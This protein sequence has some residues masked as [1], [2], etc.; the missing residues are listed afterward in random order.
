MNLISPIYAA[1]APAADVDISG[2][3]NPASNIPLTTT[4]GGLLNL[5]NG[6]NILNLIFFF[7]GLFF[8]V[9][10]ILAGWDFM[11]SSG[12]PKKVAA[13]STRITNGLI[14]LIMAITA[15]VVVRIVTTMIGLPGII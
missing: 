15:F 13:A 8:F 9:N 2:L 12:D 14:G 1:P 5:N 10:L 4:L 7:V 3:Y 11:M 6:V